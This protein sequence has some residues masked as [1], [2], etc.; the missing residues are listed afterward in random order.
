MIV[1]PHGQVA[2]CLAADAGVPVLEDQVVQWSEFVV[3]DGH[4]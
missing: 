2:I 4:V 3:E 1:N